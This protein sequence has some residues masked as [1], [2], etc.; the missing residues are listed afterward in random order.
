MPLIS[1]RTF[2]LLW[3]LCV[4]LVGAV[5]GPQLLCEPRNGR[6]DAPQG[7]PRQ[8]AAEED[9]ETPE[10]KLGHQPLDP[11]APVVPPE[12]P[13]GSWSYEAVGAAD[14]TGAEAGEAESATG[15]GSVEIVRARRKG[16]LGHRWVRSIQRLEPGGARP[17]WSALG[18]RLAFD[19]PGDLGFRSVFV[20]DMETGSRR[21]ITCDEWGFRKKSVLSPEWHPS[22][23]FVVVLVQDLPRRLLPDP[24]EMAGMH[25]GL[26]SELWILTD[27]GRYAWQLTRST[28]QGR[29]V[30]DAQISYEG[31]R[32]AWT[33]RVDS[34]AGRD[35]SWVVRLADLDMGKV[36]SIEDV[37]TLRPTSWPAF[38]TVEGFTEDDAG[39][40]LSATAN[41]RPGSLALRYDLDTL[42]MEPV[43]AG[44]S[45]NVE[46]RNV[47]RG[48]R[49]V[50]ASDRNLAAPRFLPYRGDLWFT[51]PLG[52]RQERLTFF[53]DPN[54][55]HSLGEAMITDAAWS[56]DGGAVI[57]SVVSTE[58]GPQD[59]A[60]WRIDL[61]SGLRDGDETPARP[62]G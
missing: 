48:E 34:T 17:A 59:E 10:R 20:R 42:R 47:P 18:D 1:A 33:E 54:S 16:E 28:D 56:P 43:D 37:K 53:N 21:C 46:P 26:H 32:I 49:I 4:L 7:E 23:D 31:D 14:G 9:R 50:F 29:A 8:G 62:G 57:L 22:G 25:R 36:P 19:A 41:G 38:V 39:L 24:A 3:V 2:R 55:G 51:T 60:L 44:G 11:D 45:W 12:G 13:T 30:L 35:G 6:T 40:W 15:D 58:S 52:L 27:D 61:S 5:A